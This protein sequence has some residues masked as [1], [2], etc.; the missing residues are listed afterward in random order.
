VN[1]FAIF[2]RLALDSSQY[3]SGLRGAESRTTASAN[4]MAQ[5][6]KKVGE[7]AETLGKNLS[8]FV[9]APLV[10]FGATSIK[11]AGDFEAAMNRVAGITRATGVEFQ[12]LENLAK[13]LG[14][15]T[16][17][18]ASQAADAMGFLAMAGFDTNQIISALPGT[19]EL[20]AAGSLDLARAADI[21]SN[22]L[23]G[24]GL[25]AEEVGR[26]NDVLALAS[27]SANTNVEQLGNAFKFVAP[28]ASAMGVTIEES[29]AAIGIMSDAGIQGEMAGTALR[30]ILAELAKE[31]DT[32]GVS[33]YD[34]NGVMLPLADI[35]AQ[36]ESR[37]FT[38]AESMGE[39]GMRAGPALQALLSRGSGALRDL[40]TNLEG[41]GGTAARL[42]ATNME[43]FNGA[44]LN[45]RSAVEGLQIAIAQSGLLD[46]FQSL[47]ERLTGVIRQLST[48]DPAVLRVITVVSGLAAAVGPLLFV[49]GRLL[50]EIPRMVA[51][52]NV[53]RG[54]MLV[55]FAP[56]LGIFV[57][58]ASAVVALGFYLHGRRDSLTAQIDAAVDK[59]KEM[60]RAIGDVNDSESLAGAVTK[61]ADMIGPEGS[62]GRQAF[63]NYA[64][65]IT[66]TSETAQ[67]AF[68]LIRRQAF[69]TANAVELEALRMR[70]S[71]LATQLQSA[72]SMLSVVGATESGVRERLAA[73]IAE[74]EDVAVVPIEIIREIQVLRDELEELEQNGGTAFAGMERSAAAAQ[75]TVDSL[76]AEIAKIDEQI[77]ALTG[78]SAGLGRALEPTADGLK[79]T[80]GALDD[81]GGALDEVGDA[82]DKTADDF[83]RLSLAALDAELASLR[84]A[85]SLA[86]TGEARL[87]LQQQI[88]T[89]LA[90]REAMRLT[91]GAARDLA[92]PGVTAGVSIALGDPG[93]TVE[94]QSQADAAAL[95]ARRYF[96]LSAAERER[97]EAFAKQ[98]ALQQAADAAG[99]GAAQ[100][101]PSLIDLLRQQADA[102]LNG[103]Q[104][105]AAAASEA[106]A[107]GQA[108]QDAGL[109][110]GTGA[111]DFAAHAQSV[112]DR[113]NEMNAGLGDVITTLKQTPQEAL[114]SADAFVA[115]TRAQVALGRATE[116][117]VNRALEVQA[118]ALERVMATLS[119]LDPLYADLMLRL[120]GV[121]DELTTTALEAAQANLKLAE[122]AVKLTQ[123]QVAL[124]EAT[125]DDV[126][127]ALINQVAALQ[128][129]R[130]EADPLS[131]AYLNASVQLASVL[132]G[133]QNS[134]AALLDQMSRVKENTAEWEALETQLEAIRAIMAL[135]NLSFA[136]FSAGAIVSRAALQTQ[137][138]QIIAQ[139]EPLSMFSDE[140][141][142][143][144]QE[145]LQVADLMESMGM[146]TNLP[147][148][149]ISGG[150]SEVLREIANEWR[151]AGDN[152]K[153]TAF[154]VGA[155]FADLVNRV[156]IF[157][158]ALSAFT[159]EIDKGA[160]KV[161]VSFNAVEFF[162]G[163]LLEGVGKLESFQTLISTAS[164][165]LGEFAQAA[166][167]P[168]IDVFLVLL[169]AI[170]PLIQVFGEVIGVVLKPFVFIFANVLAPLLRGVA[171]II[172]RTY[173][174]FAPFIG[175]KKI[176]KPSARVT[177]TN[178]GPRVVSISG[179]RLEV[180]GLTENLASIAGQQQQLRALQDFL[181]QAQTQ[182]ERD[183]ARRFI[184]ITQNTIDSMMGREQQPPAPAVPVV[185]PTAGSIEA[186]RAEA[187]QLQA[188]RARTTDPARIADINNR[189]ATINAEIQRLESLG[190][191]EAPGAAPTPGREQAPPPPPGTIAALEEQR[192]AL[193]AQLLVAQPADIP[194]LNLRIA[195]LSE[196]INRMRRLGLDGD[197][198]INA[199]VD[200]IEQVAFGR[201]PQAVQLAVATPLVEASQRMLDAA[202]VMNSV[203]GSMLP[204]GQAGF[205]ALPPFTSAI[206]RMTPV[207]ER[208]LEEG[209]SVM[210]G[211][212]QS[213]PMSSPTAFLRGA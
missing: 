88:E 140:Y 199:V 17:F 33:V 24:Y 157:S 90:L 81:V 201:T 41:A 205:G 125:Q 98:F 177:E 146:K 2:G 96:E 78:A 192:R 102:Y 87:D 130:A 207:L 66:A 56:P 40:T 32:L 147:A 12:Q 20:A 97:S 35:L 44:V 95:L 77:L 93:V 156:P 61:L 141:K 153:A 122:N 75:R 86:T 155:Q 42:A 143:L 64:E 13:E 128:A 176:P 168:L 8:V 76:T 127:A 144:Y 202:N 167:G 7:A 54:A 188:E 100:E 164:E 149:R 171:E 16:Q 48:L 124:G 162:G 132:D 183:F 195:E 46:F 27:I 131:D 110:A 165:I 79:D 138:D 198:P 52:F 123:A 197:T 121:R 184:E 68:E 135:I 55:L 180:T 39:F 74:W 71:L 194:A 190:L 136:D 84:L 104:A 200:A 161:D 175:A 145:L 151:K 43:G 26:V 203:F 152:L 208:L 85:Q 99:L 70:R 150:I 118:V 73:L 36:L 193:Q 108:F 60:S 22:V 6:W 113:T 159:L 10:A 23:T 47:V 50:V 51:A 111:Q 212:Q 119:P 31:S 92:D 196:E 172:R 154:E 69:E 209:V 4:R 115:L 182:Q 1:A 67:E 103:A 185:P 89:V 49:F 80:G 137:H 9:T 28:V 21:A 19:L 37:G 45:L 211:Q 160:G 114:A 169:E 59:A 186:L 11:T 106:F 109:A 173:N 178:T 129:V 206:E 94:L 213:G 148:I 189:L 65:E 166:L 25:Q 204:G 58:A 139:M 158:N 3:D 174:F 170:K 57:V 83:N 126:N 72:Q 15:T 179:D 62:P 112:I 187:S 30:N 142:R 133:L 117:D 191:P 116:D 82:A 107:L 105:A 210:M 101:L 18:S 38:T 91:L 120:A 63:V 163:M 134:E 53:L 29:A 181:A 34:T 5:D 14:A